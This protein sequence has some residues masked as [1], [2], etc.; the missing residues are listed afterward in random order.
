VGAAR[1]GFKGLIPPPEASGAPVRLARSADLRMV[2]LATAAWGAAWLGTWAV[3]AAV[4]AATACV[5]LALV[6][7]ALRR[8]PIVLSAALVTVVIVGAGVVD[9]HRLRHGPVARLAEHEA[10]VSADVEIRRDPH[11]VAAR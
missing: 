11:Q 4:G 9:V 8:S 7:A 10:V 2:P 1:T 6:V 5:A 3:P